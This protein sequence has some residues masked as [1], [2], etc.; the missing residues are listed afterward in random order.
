[1]Y[2]EGV[3]DVE[4]KRAVTPAPIYWGIVA[5]I[6]GRAGRTAVARAA[7]DSLLRSTQHQP[8][9]AGVIAEAYAGVADKEQALDWLER[10]YA[11]HSNDM[12][13]LKVAPAYPVLRGGPRYHPFLERVRFGNP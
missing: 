6:D 4:P 7:I 11:Q 9:Q 13:T 10:A 12:T 2:G 3:G 8:V 1:M 5:Y